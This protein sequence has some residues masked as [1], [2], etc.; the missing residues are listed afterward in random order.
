MHSTFEDILKVLDT[1]DEKVLASI[2]LAVQLLN[3][4]REILLKN[5]LDLYT[6][7]D[8][9]PF[10]GE[11]NPNHLGNIRND[12]AHYLKL[13]TNHLLSTTDNLEH[14]LSIRPK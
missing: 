8:T 10:E 12:K 7:A 2:K 6:E 5:S 4:A 3:E 11:G 1:D 9:N 14:V 13:A